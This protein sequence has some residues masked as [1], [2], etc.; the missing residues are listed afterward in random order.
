[1]TST[2]SSEIKQKINTPIS[3]STLEE[4][5]FKVLNYLEL[6]KFNQIEQFVDEKGIILYTPIS[7]RKLGHYSCL[8]LKNGILSYW[9]SYGYNLSYTA[10]KSDYMQKSPEKDEDY[11][12]SLVRDFVKRGG[13]FNIN[14][15]KFQNLNES[16][17]DC[18]RWCIIRLIKRE[19]SHNEFEK[20]F[21]LIKYPNMNNDELVTMLTYLI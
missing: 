17:S 7:Q 3:S 16:V 21:K 15:I 8:W 19:L 14:T 10:S 13:N 20:W 4:L 18:G 6:N 1:M 12:I 5:G 9:C 2:L 11:M